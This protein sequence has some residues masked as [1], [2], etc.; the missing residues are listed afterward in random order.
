[1]PRELTVVSQIAVS[2]ADNWHQTNIV[3]NK[4]TNP[5]YGSTT[6]VCH[7]MESIEYAFPPGKQTFQRTDQER[8]W[9]ERSP[10]AFFSSMPG[11]KTRR[12]LAERLFE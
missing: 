6:I 1:M 9:N 2:T 8:K 10:Y 3:P 4:T 5:A 11:V 7:P 12:G